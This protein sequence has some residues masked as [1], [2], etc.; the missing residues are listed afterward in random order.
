[1]SHD[2]FTMLGQELCSFKNSPFLPLGQKKA[3]SDDMLHSG[4]S[5]D[6][7]RLFNQ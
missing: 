1:M 6:P 5:Y 2:F 3:P 4:V 7:N